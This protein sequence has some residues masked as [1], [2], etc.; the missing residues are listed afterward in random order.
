MRE[1]NPRHI[2]RSLGFKYASTL[3]LNNSRLSM[4]R[5]PIYYHNKCTPLN[6]PFINAQ[7]ALIKGGAGKFSTAVYDSITLAKVSRRTQPR[8]RLRMDFLLNKHWQRDPLGFNFPFID[9]SKKHKFAPHYNFA[10]NIA[11]LIRLLAAPR[12]PWG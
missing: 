4:P 10:F 9:S 5:L 12:T 6:F 3:Y 2:K 7:Y 11:V 8:V 1:S